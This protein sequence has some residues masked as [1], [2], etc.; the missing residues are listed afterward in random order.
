MNAAQGS[1]KVLRTE[2]SEVT[3]HKN[4][5]EIALGEPPHTW[6]SNRRHFVPRKVRSRRLSA[7][8]A[9]SITMATCSSTIFP[10]AVIDSVV[11]Q[12][13]AFLEADEK[14]QVDDCH[15]PKNMELNDC[16]KSA[17]L[18]DAVVRSITSKRDNF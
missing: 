10:A 11:K 1:L 18:S 8:S 4:N 13:D 17:P 12:M 9:S 16:M 14:N 15:L 3:E 2:K 5:E 6:R 7:V